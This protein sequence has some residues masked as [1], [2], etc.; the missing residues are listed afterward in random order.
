MAILDFPKIAN[1]E[2]PMI[3]ASTGSAVTSAQSAYAEY[4][5][6][7]VVDVGIANGGRKG[8][9]SSFGVVGTSQDDCDDKAGDIA[10]LITD[11]SF[12]ACVALYK[13]M[14][15]YMKSS[16][17]IGNQ[18]IQRGS[19]KYAV[20]TWTNGLLEGE[21]GT[22]PQTTINGQV[23]LPFVDVD[24]MAAS[25]ASFNTYILEG[26]FARARANEAGNGF[27]VGISRARLGVKINDYNSLQAKQLTRADSAAGIADGVLDDRSLS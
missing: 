21:T 15:I 4:T 9:I 16:T 8:A 23:Y 6:K 20:I 5:V 13:K 24:R 3:D 27:V 18:P 7:E 19:S 2:V 1:N 11:C 17:N 14:G 10:Q 25:L 12:G 22:R 26:S